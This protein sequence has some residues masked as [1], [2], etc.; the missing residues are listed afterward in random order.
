VSHFILA[1]SYSKET[2]KCQSKKTPFLGFDRRIAK[3]QVIPEEQ[4]AFVA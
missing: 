2:E 4:P 3:Y 1:I